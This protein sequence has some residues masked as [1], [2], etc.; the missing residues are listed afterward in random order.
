MGW[1]NQVDDSCP[2]LHGWDASNAIYGEESHIYG[3]TNWDQSRNMARG[4]GWETSTDLFK[5][6]NRSASMEMLSSEKEN[7]STRSGDEA[8]VA[9]SIQPAQSEQ[10]L[11]DQQADSTDINQSIKTFE[12]NDIEVPLINQED[13]SDVAKISRKDDVH[14]CHVYLSKLDISAD[15]TEPELFNKCTSLIDLDQSISS[16]GDDSSI[17]CME[18]TE[19]KR[20]P[21][22]L[23]SYALFVSTD[24]SIFQKSISLYKMQKENLW[25]EDGEKLKVFSKL[26]PNSD[27]GDQNAEDDKIEKL[28][29]TDDMQGVEDA[30]PNFETEADHKNS[31]QEVGLCMETLKQEAGLPVGYTIETSKEPVSASDPVNMEETSEFDQGLVEPDVKEKPLCV[32]SFEESDS[33]LPSEVKVELMESGSNNDELKFVDT[34]CGALVNSDDVSSEACEAVMPESI[35][36]G[37]PVLFTL[38]LSFG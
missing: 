9:Q 1:H 19:A 18:A 36:S 25:A 5:G 11:A 26:V 38:V 8:L 14:L 17:L 34:R 32:G 30:L 2:P 33:P 7:N 27:Q 29:P 15:L 13:T 4:R 12:K 10:T 28:C 23:M 31:L 24:D 21:H 16:E 20:V 22:R 3:R 6:P 37:Y 35:V